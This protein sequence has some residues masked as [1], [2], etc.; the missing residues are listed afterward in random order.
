M[1]TILAGLDVKGR[2]AVTAP[3]FSGMGNAIGPAAGEMV[4][5]LGNGDPSP[6]W[7]ASCFYIVWAFCLISGARWV[8]GRTRNET[9]SGTP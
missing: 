7:P 8:D 3:A 9:G 1:M 6:G 5:T 4:L 2:V